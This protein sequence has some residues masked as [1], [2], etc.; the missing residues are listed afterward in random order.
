MTSAEESAICLRCQ[1]PDC[2]E[3]DSRCGLNNTWQQRM[4]RAL[5]RIEIERWQRVD[6]AY[7]TI[8]QRQEQRA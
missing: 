8:K 1:L 7:R 3:R 6:A 4:H 2:D 5:S